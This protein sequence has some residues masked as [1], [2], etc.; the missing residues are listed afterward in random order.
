MRF[1]IPAGLRPKLYAVGLLAAAFLLAAVGQ[2]ELL[3]SHLPAGLAAYAAAIITFCLALRSPAPREP[4]PTYVAQSG[5]QR[6]SRLIWLSLALAVLVA[7]MVPYGDPPQAERWEQLIIWLASVILFTTGV[8]R[9]TAWHPPGWRTLL[10]GIRAHRGEI[11]GLLA[12][13]LFALALR[14]VDLEYHPYPFSNDEGWVGIDARTLLQAGFNSFFRVGYGTQP[15]LTF[16]PTSISE[17][18]F[19]Q[20]IFA[21]RFGSAVDGMLT[22]LFLYLAGREL[23]NRRVA[24]LSAA[25]LAVMPVHIQ[26]SR[27]GFNNIVAG[28]YAVLLVWLA[29]RALRVGKVSSYLW[30]GLAAGCAL[31]TYLGSRLD[32]ALAAGIFVWICITQRNYLRQHRAHL[33]IFLLA[34]L[35]VAGPQIS[36]FFTHPDDFGA[37]INGDGVIQNGWLTN[38]YASGGIGGVV[39]GL[40]NQ[41]AISSLVYI[42]VPAAYGFYSSTQPYF[43]PF[44]AVFL[45]LGMGYAIYRARRPAFLVLLAWFWSVTVIGGMLTSSPPASQRLILGFPAAALMVAL[46]LDQATC[47]LERVLVLQARRMLSWIRLLPAI[48]CVLAVTGIAIDGLGYYFFEYRQADGFQDTSNEL[49]YESSLLARQLGTSYQYVLLGAPRTFTYF[50]NYDYF[51]PDFTKV[52]QVDPILGP[53]KEAIPSPPALYIAIPDRRSE[54]NL[55][56]QA[57]PGGTW[58]EVHRRWDS[59]DTLFLAYIYPAALVRV[60]DS[61]P[62]TPLAV[63]Q[64]LMI[65]SLLFIGVCFFA[66]LFLELRLIIIIRKRWF[67]R[68]I[69]GE[70]R[71]GK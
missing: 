24:I 54:L 51:L 66:A 38:Q 57:L 10:N 13:C 50:A 60:P 43:P 19:G 45:V 42:S 28:F 18:I 56:A 70:V 2:S 23:F 8:L 26:F 41:L 31:Y 48:L 6:I 11:I 69:K 52:D 3:Q 71:H 62:D 44:E 20:T 35:I 27:L 5:F 25:L 55:V 46:E 36:D 15:L 61:L 21:V 30:V 22:V 63:Q 39:S 14:L 40:A 29:F 4:A 37:R 34:I 16:V 1:P 58:L 12:L 53:V 47:A 32:V 67:Q 68:K 9:S 17:A 7:L 49:I 59:H 64:D 33:L 65:D